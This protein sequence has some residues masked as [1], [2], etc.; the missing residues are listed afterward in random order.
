MQAKLSSLWDEYNIKIIKSAKLLEMCAELSIKHSEK[1]LGRELKAS[2]KPQE[3]DDS[4]IFI[5][6]YN[7]H[8]ITVFQFLFYIS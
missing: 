7:Y 8:S 4:F 1:E 5:S 3:E 2:E 6:Q